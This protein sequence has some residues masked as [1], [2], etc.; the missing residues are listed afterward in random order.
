MR[1]EGSSAVFST[2]KTQT[3]Q[4]Y[5]LAGGPDNER[6]PA[7]CAAGGKN[8]DAFDVCQTWPDVFIGGIGHPESHISTLR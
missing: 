4:Q 5:A 7:G 3:A 6:K 1:R 2:N 8:A